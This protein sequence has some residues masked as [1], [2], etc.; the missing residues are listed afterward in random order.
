MGREPRNGKGA[1]ISGSRQESSSGWGF[2]TTSRL[3]TAFGRKRRAMSRA[4]QEAADIA[5]A[6]GNHFKEQVA[7]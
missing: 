1:G 5:E 7:D 4:G 6:L 3:D 2:P